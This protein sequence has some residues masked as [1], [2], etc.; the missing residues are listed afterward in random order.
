[1]GTPTTPVVGGGLV[2][3][4]EREPFENGPQISFTGVFHSHETSEGAWVHER[5][6]P[7]EVFFA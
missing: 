3:A 4:N 7:H 2:A 6:F 1:M 5:L